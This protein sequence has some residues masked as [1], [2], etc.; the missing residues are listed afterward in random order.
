[1]PQSLEYLNRAAFL[2]AEEAVNLSKVR[3]LVEHNSVRI[4]AYA[5]ELTIPLKSNISCC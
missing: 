3:P 5:T 4:T 2:V 1:M